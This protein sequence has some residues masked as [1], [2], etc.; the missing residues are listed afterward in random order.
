[1]AG[2]GYVPELLGAAQAMQQEARK[3]GWLEVV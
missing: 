1:L 3:R 2:N